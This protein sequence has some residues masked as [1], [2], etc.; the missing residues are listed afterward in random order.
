MS[1]VSIAVTK[2]G[3]KGDQIAMEAYG[4]QL[5]RSVGMQ[6]T[7][8]ALHTGVLIFIWLAAWLCVLLLLCLE[9]S[10]A[11]LQCSSP[12]A[13]LRGVSRPLKQEHEVQV[14][15]LSEVTSTAQIFCN[16]VLDLSRAELNDGHTHLA[17][18]YT[19]QTPLS[20]GTRG[21]AVD[22]ASVG[23]NECWH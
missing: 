23:T 8:V 2:D 15:V 10:G 9:A 14:L 3:L 21:P 7:D 4:T 22:A 5:L 16:E 1:S 17:K 11:S 18:P 20:E 13:T 12:L 19:S 6:N